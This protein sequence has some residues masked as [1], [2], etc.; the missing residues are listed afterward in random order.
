MWWLGCSGGHT[1]QEWDIHSPILTWK[2]CVGCLVLYFGDLILG[3]F[4]CG[5]SREGGGVVG[6]MLIGDG[7]ISVVC[8]LLWCLM[9]EGVD[10]CSLDSW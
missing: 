2:Y 9:V 5:E 1:S 4:G 10:V 8:G 6:C 7:L 3:F